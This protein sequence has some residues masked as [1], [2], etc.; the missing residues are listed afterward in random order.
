MKNGID[1][2][3]VIEGNLKAVKCTDDFGGCNMWTLY[4]KTTRGHFQQV[5]WTGLN[6][7]QDFFKTKLPEYVEQYN[8]KKK[9]NK[10]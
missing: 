1:P 7:V 5:D 2:F 10:I 3:E 8:S 4:I 6:R 9:Y